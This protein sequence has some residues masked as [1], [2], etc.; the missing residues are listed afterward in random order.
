MPATKTTS[1]PGSGARPGSALLGSEGPNPEGFNDIRAPAAR[2]GPV[3]AVAYSP[4]GTRL[5]TGSL[6]KTARIWDTATGHAITKLAHGSPVNAV[7]YSPDG[8]RL[9]T[10]CQDKTARIGAA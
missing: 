6:D 2:S 1:N 8:T 9:A 10:G 7:A 3:N 5:A 4:D